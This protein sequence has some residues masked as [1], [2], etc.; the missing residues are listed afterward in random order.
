MADES[1]GT[2]RYKTARALEMA[3]KEAARRSGRDVNRA[4]AD[5]WHGRLLERVFS[6][7]EPPFVL[8]GGRGMLARTSS[9]RYVSSS[10]TASRRTRRVPWD[11]TSC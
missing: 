7:D 10:P 4:M 11:A 2:K 6:E 5:F 1:G 3:L 8:K 9:A